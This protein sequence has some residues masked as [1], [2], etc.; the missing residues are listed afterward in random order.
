MRS[1]LPLPR[2]EK[3]SSERLP[4]PSRSVFCRQ[5]GVSPS[6]AAWQLTCASRLAGAR[7][8]GCRSQ[9][10]ELGPPVGQGRNKGL[11]TMSAFSSQQTLAV[12]IFDN[13]SDLKGGNRGGRWGQHQRLVGPSFF[14]DCVGCRCHRGG[15]VD[16][17]RQRSHR[18][19][20]RDSLERR[21]VGPKSTGF[22]CADHLHRDPGPVF[23]PFTINQLNVPLSASTQYF[24]VVAPSTS[25][26]DWDFTNASSSLNSNSI[27]QGTSWSSGTSAPLQMSVVAV[28][29][30]ATVGLLA[31]AGFA[32]GFA[33]IRR[34]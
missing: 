3:W 33:L 18:L 4:C 14:D 1:L 32:G 31:T 12:T 19:F 15:V 27:N 9:G 21:G 2:P 26:L 6:P 13:R 34:R 11:L 17:Q 23:S 28:P 7:G 24:V 8:C 16:G 30:P 5:R 25:G 22:P 10:Y 29:E 20:S